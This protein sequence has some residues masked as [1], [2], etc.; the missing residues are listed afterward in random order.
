MA[1]NYQNAT[2]A[3]LLQ[4]IIGQIN[5]DSEPISNVGNILLSILEQTPYEDEPK[6]VLAELFLKLKAKLEETSFEPY[7]KEP[8]S[9]IAEILLSILNETEYTGTADSRI[10]QLLLELKDELENY[11]ELTASGAISSFITNVSKPLVSCEVDESATKLFQR[12]NNFCE[13]LFEQGFI[14]ASG[15]ETGSKTSIRSVN[16]NSCKPNVEFYCS[17][18]ESPSAYLFFYD[19]NKTFINRIQCNNAVVLSP[20]NAHFF[21]FS[22]Y[23]YGEGGYDVANKPV[24]IN[25]PK[26]DTEYHAYNANSADYDV[27]EIENIKTFIGV[28]NIFTDNGDVSITYKA[29]ET[30]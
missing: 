6:S 12:G 21:R 8:Q 13:E 3:Q 28:N 2:I 17:T 4:A 5:F 9:V 1:N 30:D 14:N 27:A 25:N 24:S 18:F 23:N 10:A 22:C 19:E 15:V 26:T 29:K 11:V 7:D 16:Y 20:N